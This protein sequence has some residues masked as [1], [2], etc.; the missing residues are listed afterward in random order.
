MDHLSMGSRLR[1][2]LGR[3]EKSLTDRYRRIYIDLDAFS[4]EVAG[5]IKA[6]H[7]LEVGCGEGMLTERLHKVYPAAAIIG[8]DINPQIGRLYSVPNGKVRFLN[9]PAQAVEKEFK[10]G[11]DLIVFCDVLHHVPVAEIL[12][13][14]RSS[15]KMLKTGGTI[16]IKEWQKRWNPIYL[17]AYFSDR[18][19]TGDRICYRRIGE[20]ENL[21]NTAFGPKTIKETFYIPPWIN[22]IAFRIEIG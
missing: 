1:S 18:W 21:L 8:I 10:Q 5:R 11:F 4:N 7:I 16:I 19:I 22:N 20:W 2:Y 17:L 6:E 14:L 3:H 9:Q 12:P 15:L 13:L